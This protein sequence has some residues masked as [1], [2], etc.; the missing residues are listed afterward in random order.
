MGAL[1][2]RLPETLDQALTCEAEMEMKPRSVVVRQALAEYLERMEKERFM[3]SMAEAARA[4]ANDPAASSE[5]A[6]IAESTVSDAADA[7]IASERSADA[8]PT[9]AWWR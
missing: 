8:D 9:E 1:S 3:A 4:L 5:S 7:V 6:Q 2:L